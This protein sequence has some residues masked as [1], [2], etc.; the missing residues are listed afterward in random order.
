MPRK[1]ILPLVLAT[2]GCSFLLASVF[3]ARSGNGPDTLSF[4]RQASSDKPY[5][6]WVFS[7]YE[8]T[9]H[10]DSGFIHRLKAYSATAS[11]YESFWFDKI[12]TAQKDICTAVTESLHKEASATIVGRVLDLTSLPLWHKWNSLDPS[13]SAKF[14]ASDRFMSKM[15]Y[16][17]TCYDSR[18]KTFKL[19]FGKGVQLIE[20]LWGMLRD[21]FD[22]YCG[23][24][25]FQMPGIPSDTSGQSK[26]HIMPQGYAPYTYWMTDEDLDQDALWTSHGLPPWHSSLRPTW[27]E[28]VPDT[29]LFQPPQNIFLDLGSSYFGEWLGDSAAASGRWFYNTY[30][31][32]G[33]A[34]DRFI[35]VEAETLNDP[36]AFEQLPSDLVGVYTLMNVALSMNH[37]D[38]LNVIEMIKRLVKPEDFFV[39]KLDI[40]SAPIEEPIIAS[41]LQDDTHNEGASGLV[42]EL[43]RIMRRIQSCKPWL[44]YRRC[45]SIMSTILQ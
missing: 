27:N 24:K 25:G 2:L 12:E 39:L 16:N 5:C 17:R 19:A 45:L 23:D 37:G 7:Q 42:D 41:L 18:S 30:H 44:I 29:T 40:D 35:A 28:R 36:T 11:D 20:P 3:R 14:N 13:L 32:R 1:P 43:V 15:H 10:S 21:P 38:K 6:K 34:F 9:W 4:R 22:K 31:A 33:P 26:A 8:R